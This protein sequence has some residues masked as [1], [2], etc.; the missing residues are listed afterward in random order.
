MV[1]GELKNIV[2]HPLKWVINEK[3]LMKFKFL[4]QKLLFYG[5]P[6]SGNLLAI[7][8]FSIYVCFRSTSLPETHLPGVLRG[9]RTTRSINGFSVN[10]WHHLL[11]HGIFC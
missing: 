11:N 4:R 6:S 5:H 10:E 7:D 2:W 3:I 8:Q 1:I 9:P